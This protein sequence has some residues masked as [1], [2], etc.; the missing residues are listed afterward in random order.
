VDIN[1]KNESRQQDKQTI[2]Q[3]F[4]TTMAALLGMKIN[5]IDAVK[6]INNMQ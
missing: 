4:I 3:S 5:Y 6:L 2:M 1:T